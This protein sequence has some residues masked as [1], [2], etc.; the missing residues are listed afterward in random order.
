[1]TIA[2]VDYGSRR[3]GIAAS[4][5]AGIV[6]YPVGVIRRRSLNSDLVALCR[7][8]KALGATRVIVG[9]P[10]NMDGTTGTSAQAAEHFAQ[11]LRAASGL[12]VELQDERLSTW[13]ARERLKT[14]SKRP[15]ASV[16]AIAAV[17]ILENWFRT[18]NPTS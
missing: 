5:P 7:Q 6:I 16:D 9:W 10:L 2:A 1:M 3:L 12:E 4:D 15:R 17:I 13:E 8:L 11:C 14:R 18:R